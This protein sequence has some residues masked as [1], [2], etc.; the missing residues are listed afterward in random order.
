MLT[1][2][3]AL[4]LPLAEYC[5]QLWSPGTRENIVKLESIQRSFTAKIRET[6]DLD[7]WER[8]EFLKLYSL[9]R[10]RERYLIIYTWKMIRGIVPNFNN[11]NLML[12]T[13]QHIRFGDLCVVPSFN[14]RAA[15]SVRTRHEQSFSVMGPKLFNSLPKDL[16]EFS[17]SPEVFKTKLDRFLLTV[18]DRPPLPHY[19]QTAEGNSLIQQLA[20]MRRNTSSRRR[21]HPSVARA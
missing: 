7:Y 12:R 2:V 18:P 8:L 15:G 3:K 20:D 4:I 21:R 17:G 1:L 14:A 6:Q 13:K 5:C 16:R 11:E 9:Q 19:H 10:R